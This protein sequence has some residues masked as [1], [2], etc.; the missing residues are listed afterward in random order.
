MAQVV[1]FFFSDYLWFVITFLCFIIVLCTPDVASFNI[2]PAS[3]DLCRLL[4]Y[5]ASH[6]GRGLKRH[7]VGSGLDLNYMTV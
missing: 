6:L 3:C 7:Y 1:V 5:V 4:I 2:F